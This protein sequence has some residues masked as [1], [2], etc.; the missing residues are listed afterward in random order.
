MFN[1]DPS[2]TF[3]LYLRCVEFARIAASAGSNTFNGHLSNEE[4]FNIALISFAFALGK[5]S[6]AKK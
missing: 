4:R 6:A 5:E 2:E 1:I 3:P